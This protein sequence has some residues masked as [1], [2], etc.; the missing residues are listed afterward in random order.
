L[1]LGSTAG[2]AAASVSGIT[3]ASGATLLVSQLNQ[4]SDTAAVTLS[5]GTI[6]TAAG[7][8][9]VFGDLNVGSNSFLEF[10]SGAAGSVSFGTYAPSALLTINNFNLGSTLVFKSN[11]SSSITNASFFTFSNG[12]ISGY[13]W[14]ESA[15]TFTITAI[16]EPVTLLAAVGLLALML[17]SAGPAL[18][19][20]RTR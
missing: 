12:G 10:G 14:N 3:V 20:Q 11:L 16:P 19:G 4:V 1:Q 5:G 13:S 18:L 7:V 9:E 17:G 15:S 2:G 8:S 6:R